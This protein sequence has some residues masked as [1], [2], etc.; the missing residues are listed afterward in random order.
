MVNRIKTIGE[1][2]ISLRKLHGLSQL[3]LASKLNITRQS[4]SNYDRNT[5]VSHPTSILLQMCDILNC[6][7][8]D[9]YGFSPLT[10][11]SPIEAQF[12]DLS[13]DKQNRVIEYINY[14]HSE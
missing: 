1:N 7:P 6:M 14:L 2:I 13:L 4:L 12:Y 11:V 10:Y 3:E 8:N 5:V 9:I